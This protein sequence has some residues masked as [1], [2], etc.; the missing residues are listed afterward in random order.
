MAVCCL[1]PSC[2]EDFFKSFSTV[3]FNSSLFQVKSRLIK[4]I[5]EPTKSKKEEREFQ[6]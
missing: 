5:K 3:C 4:L 6:G 2:K 1:V